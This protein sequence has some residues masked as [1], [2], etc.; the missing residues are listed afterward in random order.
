MIKQTILAAAL[1]A[2]T[3]GSGADAAATNLQG[4]G[5]HGA[6]QIEAQQIGFKK[7]GHRRSFGHRGGFR[8]R[9]GFRS[10]GGFGFQR[11]FFGKAFRGGHGG[12]G[13]TVII[14]KGHRGKA[15]ILKDTHGKTLISPGAI[16]IK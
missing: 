1:A 15:I 3:L 14:D 12:D 8:S 13:K 9:S 11:G 4:S 7:F 2:T 5:L 6:V 10:R 16:V